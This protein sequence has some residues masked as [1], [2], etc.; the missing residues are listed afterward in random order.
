MRGF[1]NA[2][3]FVPKYNLFHF[4]LMISVN[5]HVAEFCSDLFK[6][7]VTYI[8]MLMLISVRGWPP[9]FEQG[10]T[11]VLFFYYASSFSAF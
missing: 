5:A 9:I 4:T 8:G 11:L 2:S 7:V 10:F 6:F 3:H 1:V